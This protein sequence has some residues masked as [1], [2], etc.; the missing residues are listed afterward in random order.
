MHDQLFANYA[1]W[2]DNSDPTS[3]YIGFAATI[4]ISTTTFYKDYTSKVVADAVTNSY[5][6]SVSNNLSYTPTFFVNGVRIANPQGYDAFK[7][8]IDDAASS[9]SSTAM[10][11][12]SSK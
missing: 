3:I 10:S 9:A 4:G 6:E 8:V 1:D 5:Q 2:E 11:S 12:S 7:K